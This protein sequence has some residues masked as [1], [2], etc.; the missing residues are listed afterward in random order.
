MYRRACEMVEGED[1][2]DGF[3]LFEEEQ[4][5]SAGS[6]RG[7]RTGDDGAKR[8][9][10]NVFDTCFE[11]VQVLLNKYPIAPTSAIKAHPSFVA[12]R[13]LLNPR[14]SQYI[15]AAIRHFGNEMNSK[16][17]R[18][19]DLFYNTENIEPVFLHG[20][21]YHTREESV[22][23]IDNLLK[24]QF[25]DEI[26]LISEFLTTLVDVI[27]RRQ[28]KLNTIV[29]H[30]PKSGGKNFFF[31]MIFGFMLS[32]GQLGTANKH[33]HFAFQDAANQRIILWDEPNYESGITDYLKKVL[34]ASPYSV[35]GKGVPDIAV[36]RTPVIVLTNTSVG[37][38]VDI[39]FSE[40]LK[41]YYWKGAHMLADVPNKPYPLAFFDILNKYNI[42][43]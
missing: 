16:T 39:D 37:F 11:E 41:I 30:S 3:D 32:Y 10:R 1:D 5:I 4:S 31:E 6:G 33:N 36:K 22:D 17:L 2:G 21:V 13:I 8:K 42:E 29:I 15:E 18:E 20:Q 43:Y 25:N 9:K 27:D 35:R 38:M 7:F 12:N 26:D 34:G 14:N 28:P 24:W 19:F 40:R 23:I